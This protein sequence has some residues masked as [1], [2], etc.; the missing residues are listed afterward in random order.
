MPSIA[1]QIYNWDNRAQ[2]IPDVH[3]FQT[4]YLGGT[5]IA[6]DHKA[7][8]EDVGLE[9]ITCHHVEGCGHCHREEVRTV[10]VADA[11]V[12]IHRRQ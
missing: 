9:C 7:R 5:Q 12:A 8:G 4:R 6:F 3:I 2:P 1:P 11:K 10:D